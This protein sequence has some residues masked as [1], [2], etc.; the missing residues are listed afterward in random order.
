MIIVLTTWRIPTITSLQ[1]TLERIL[2]LGRI[3]MP[4][5]DG[6]SNSGSEIDSLISRE[7][8][9]TDETCPALPLPLF[10]H[11]LP[12]KVHLHYGKIF[13]SSKKYSQALPEACF[14]A[15]SKTNPMTTK[16][17]HH[18][19]MWVDDRQKTDRWTDRFQPIFKNKFLVSY[20]FSLF[21]ASW[22]ISNF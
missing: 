19:Y 6:S 16:I 12:E 5:K 3:L 21:W 9:H 8:R 1:L 10:I 7:W 17:S 13:P 15:K 4:G 22:T 11:W 20:V 2:T 14:L 18:T